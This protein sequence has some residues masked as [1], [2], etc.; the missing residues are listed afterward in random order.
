MSSGLDTTT[1]ENKLT[2]YNK[3]I[4]ARK[5]NHQRLKHTIPGMK[6]FVKSGQHFGL[7]PI[8]YDQWVVIQ[9]I[10]FYYHLAGKNLAKHEIS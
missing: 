2:I 10:P 8:G 9:I 6:K 1:D 3:L 7:V 5:E 4:E